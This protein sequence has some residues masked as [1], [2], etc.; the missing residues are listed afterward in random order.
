VVRIVKRRLAADETIWIAYLESSPP[1]EWF[2]GQTYVDTLSAKAMKE[3]LSTTYEK[4]KEYVGDGFGTTIPYI[5]TDELQFAM[6]R[7]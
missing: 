1:S 2:N 3:F 6:R 4:Y 7:G 5:F